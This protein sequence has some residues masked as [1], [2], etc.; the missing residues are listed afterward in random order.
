M[1]QPGPDQ[2]HREKNGEIG[3]KHGNTLISTLRQPTGEFRA[4]NPGAHEA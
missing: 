4:G 3:R 1:Q 2:R